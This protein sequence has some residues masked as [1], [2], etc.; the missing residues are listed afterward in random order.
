MG[1]NDPIIEKVKVLT[2]KAKSENATK[3]ASG[4]RGITLNK[5]NVNPLQN[6]I[7]TPAQA[8]FFMTVLQDIFK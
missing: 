4:L 3:I 7:K 8:A 2:I 1:I 6:A 5:S